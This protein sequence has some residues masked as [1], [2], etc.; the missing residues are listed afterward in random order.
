MNFYIIIGFLLGLCFYL[1]IDNGEN[2]KPKLFNSIII[3]IL[4]S[5]Y[6]IHHWII[7]LLIFLILIPIILF[8]KYTNYF[9]L[10]LG[11]CLGSILQGLTYNDAFNIKINN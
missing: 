2:K 11:I 9:A 10:M 1:I 8:Y 4:N 3:N 5:K 6:H 7:F